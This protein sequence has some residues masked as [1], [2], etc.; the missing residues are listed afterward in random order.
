VTGGREIRA[1]FPATLEAMDAFLGRLGLR[2]GWFGRNGAAFA[3]ELLLREVLTNAVVHGCR[4]H[5]G[6]RVNCTVRQRGENF[7]FAVR[8][9]GG[10]FDWR[11][12]LGRP[13]RESAQSGRGM[14]I[15]RD[16]AS[17]FRFNSRGNG[18]VVRLKTG[19]E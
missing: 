6:L 1:D 17:A 11:A 15:L 9:E 5:P 13:V 14:S 8:D 19:G 10:G 2:D 12:M 3:S 4:S 16:Y 18:L 7:T